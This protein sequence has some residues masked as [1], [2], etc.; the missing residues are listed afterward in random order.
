MRWLAIA[1]VLVATSP[2]LENQRV[3]AY[4]TSAGALTGVAHGPAVV[5]ALDDADGVKMG[6]ATWVDDAAA[7]SPA[8]SAGGSIVI[9]Q[10]LRPPRSTRP[11][12]AR[13]EA[14]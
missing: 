7:P 3:R 5:I 13:I 11:P 6:N 2:V 4:R 1:A 10:P 12:S 8:T 14:G 9:V